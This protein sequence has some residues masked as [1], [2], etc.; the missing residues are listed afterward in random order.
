MIDIHT[1]LLFGVDDGCKTLEDSIKMIESAL[2]YGITDIILTPHYSYLRKYTANR[3]KAEENFLI[4]KGVI[5]HRGIKMNLYLG[6]EIDETDDIF[7][8][9]ENK[10]CNTMNDTKYVL[11]DF[12]MKKC[13]I[14]DYC[15]ELIVNGFIP[16]IAHPER[17][18][19]VK[20][21]SEYKKWRETGALIQINAGSIFNKHS[22]Q[23]KKM[24]R[25]ACKL[26]LVDFVA[27]DAHTDPVRFANLIK[28]YHHGS[29][30]SDKENI[31]KIFFSNQKKIISNI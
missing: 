3:R 25:L 13:N 21:I 1:H 22:A 18:S 30:K 29:K 16:I 6:S 9:L 8:F 17:Y 4:L 20:D 11:I 28:A 19:Y 26:R 10:E 14:D 2:S 7:D 12:G 15:Y 23:T 5:K 24:A 27:S 31:E